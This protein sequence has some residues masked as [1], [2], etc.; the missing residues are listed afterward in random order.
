MTY[1]EALAELDEPIEGEDYGE[2]MMYSKETGEFIL[3]SKYG[4]AYC[5]RDW[6]APFRPIKK[7]LEATDYEIVT[8]T[9]Q[10]YK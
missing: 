5:T 3:K 10:V 9:G 6:P 8:S 4:L 7:D 1:N 2:K